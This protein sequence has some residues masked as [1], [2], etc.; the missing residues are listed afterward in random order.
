MGSPKSFDT[1]SL[2]KLNMEITMGLDM[3][4]NK[5][6]YVGAEFEHRN[7]TGKISIKVGDNKLKIDF[8]NVSEIVERAGYWR[9]A[10]QIHKWFVTNVQDGNDDCGRYYVSKENMEKLLDSCKKVKE[11]H[12]LAPELL[13][14]ESGFFFGSTEYGEYY[15]EDIDTTIEILENALKEINPEVSFEYH[16]SW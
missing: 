11:N 16:S 12:Q 9:K 4:L 7:V 13:P 1:V 15:Y 10:N 3:F 5:K 8:S 14:T 2:E 6:W